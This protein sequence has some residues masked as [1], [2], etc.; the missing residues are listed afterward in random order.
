M[1]KGNKKLAKYL[2]YTT[3]VITVGILLMVFFMRKI[4]LNSSIDFSFLPP[5]Y[6]TLNALTA[7]CLIYAYV[8]IRRKNIEKHKKAM[9]MAV[10]LSFLFLLMYVLYHLTTADTLF[11]K[12]GWIRPVYFFILITHIVL[13]AFSFPFVLFTFTRGITN[14]IDKHKKLARWVFPIWL[15]VAITGPIIYLLLYPCYS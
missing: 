7:L 14:L 11:C 8:Q 13:A 12:E 4:N 9:I 15:Y 5:L 1:I 3:Y 6:S 10:S 2:D